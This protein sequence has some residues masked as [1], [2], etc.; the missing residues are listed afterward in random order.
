MTITNTDKDLIQNVVDVL[1]KSPIATLI[2]DTGFDQYE[3]IPHYG[4]LYQVY[5]LNN[6]NTLECFIAEEV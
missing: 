3:I 2:I 4:F 5:H 1:H 6:D